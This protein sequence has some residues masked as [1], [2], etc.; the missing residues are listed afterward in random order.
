MEWYETCEML[1]TN[2]KPILIDC[3]EGVGEGYYKGNETFRFNRFSVDVN[4]DY[5]YRWTEMPKSIICQN[6]NNL[7]N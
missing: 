5:V 6:L 7:K 2:S 3:E 1:P 4:A